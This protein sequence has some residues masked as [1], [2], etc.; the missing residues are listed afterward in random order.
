[1][2]LCAH[3]SGPP[4]FDKM[5]IGDHLYGMETLSIKGVKSPG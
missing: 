3:A 2:I 4:F 5:L 1:M